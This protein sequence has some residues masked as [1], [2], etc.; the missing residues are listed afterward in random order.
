MAATTAVAAAIAALIGKPVWAAAL[1]AGL[2][3][4]YWGLE[5]LAWRRGEATSTFG[6]AIGVALAGMVVR[7]GV[8]LAVLVVVGLT[9]D[10]TAFAAAAV[11][12]LV[13]FSVYIP[14]RLVAYADLSTPRQAG[15]R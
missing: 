1:G 9:A 15:A 13:A 6:G 10:K 2:V 14:L 7:L 12:F 5:L 8:V 4:A 11:S 3:L